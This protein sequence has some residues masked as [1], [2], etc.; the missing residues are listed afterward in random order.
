MY[1]EI[2]P[3][4]ETPIYTQLMY[5]IKL[6]IIKG[7][8]QAE[9]SLPSVRSLAGDLGINMHTVNKAY[10]LLVEEEILEKGSKGYAVKEI[11][12]KNKNGKTVQQLKSRLEELVIDTE[13]HAVD[14]E[15]TEQWLKEIQ[16]KIGKL[17]K[18]L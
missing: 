18:K 5:Q 14:Q 15:T 8:L 3:N 2:E 12:R 16:K 1:I 7:E 10:N 4:A 11:A 17:V 6:G 9:E 13:I